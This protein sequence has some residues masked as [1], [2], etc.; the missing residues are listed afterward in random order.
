MSKADIP[1]VRAGTTSELVRFAE[2]VKQNLDQMKGVH[3][4]TPKL[5]KLASGASLADCVA[6]INEI[7]DRLQ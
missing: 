6:K 4:N 7:I 1:S 5:E 3:K 2:A